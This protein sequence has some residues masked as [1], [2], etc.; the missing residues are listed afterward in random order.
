[1]NDRCMTFTAAVRHLD[2]PD[3]EMQVP[4]EVLIN[5]NGM[6]LSKFV[7]RPPAQLAGFF[8]EN[9]M[10]RSRRSRW[11]SVSPTVATRSRSSASS[12]HLYDLPEPLDDGSN[13]KASR[14]HPVRYANMPTR[15]TGRMKAAS[16]DAY[17]IQ[18]PDILVSKELACTGKCKLSCPAVGVCSRSL[19]HS[20]GNPT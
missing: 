15:D 4:A 11:K 17:P 6:M 19:L 3:H 8:A 12:H 13:C 2:C 9:M 5:V 7:C 14:L 16:F 10:K 1:M 20:F 18:H